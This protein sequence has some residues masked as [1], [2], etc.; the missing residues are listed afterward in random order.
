M[1]KSLFPLRDTNAIAAENK[2]S[3]YYVRQ[4]EDSLLSCVSG[5][6]V[7]F[8]PLPPPFLNTSKP[9]CRMEDLLDLKMHAVRQ[10]RF[11]LP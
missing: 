3:L 4:M 8:A 7:P 6:T 10:L 5:H 2:G 11:L 9:K 1:R